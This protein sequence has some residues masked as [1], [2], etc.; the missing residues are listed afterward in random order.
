[1]FNKFE[2]RSILQIRPSDHS[3]PKKTLLAA[4]TKPTILGTPSKKA[5]TIDPESPGRTT[6]EQIVPE[7]IEVP[8]ATHD[9]IS[10]K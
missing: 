10:S 1:M 2:I 6:L 8:D 7:G 5:Y 4:K 3:S 9:I